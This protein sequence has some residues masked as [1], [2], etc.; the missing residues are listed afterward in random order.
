MKTLYIS[1]LDGTMLNSNAEVSKIT[2][3]LLNK[4]ILNGAYI[5][6]ATART[7]ATVLKMLEKININ[8]P[9]VLMNGVCIYDI[10]KSEYVKVCGFSEN[11]K[12]ELLKII[13]M[14]SSPGF[15]YCLENGELSTYYQNTDSPN[16]YEFIRERE[17]KYAKKFTKIRNVQEP[18]NK[19]I[20]Y[21]SYNDYREKLEPMYRKIKEIEGL[22]CEFYADNYN[23][24]FWYLEVCSIEASKKNAVQFL[25]ENYSFDKIIGFGDNFNDIPLFEACD[26]SYAVE[27]AKKEVKSVATGVIG[28]NTDNAVA[29][30][31]FKN[32]S[33]EAGKDYA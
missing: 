31:I 1:D 5:S 23:Q 10:K 8:T 30:F 12:A 21:Y 18:A 16:S 28:K 3:D 24:D 11:A 6:V 27:N 9:I 20:I 32:C 17:E 25:R 22:R 29:E 2:V 26:E 4:A 19:D 13:E 7:S 33:L 14:H 15:I